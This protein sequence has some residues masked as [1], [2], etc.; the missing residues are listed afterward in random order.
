MRAWIIPF[1][2]LEVELMSNHAQEKRREGRHV[3]A[4]RAVMLLL[5][6]LLLFFS[7]FAIHSISPLERE[8]ERERCEATPVK[9]SGGLLCPLHLDII[10]HPH[11]A[12]PRSL[13]RSVFAYQL[14]NRKIDKVNRR[15]QCGSSV[16]TLPVF[17]ILSL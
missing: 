11:A 7:F 6:L 1:V 4:E 17:K 12:F 5:L 9:R 16:Y 10:V 2:S 15:K 13:F 8:R 3:D 14:W